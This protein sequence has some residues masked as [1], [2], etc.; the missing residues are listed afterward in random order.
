MARQ[1]RIEYP[2]AI[3]HVMSRGN[4]S[5][6][7]YC[8]D[9]DRQCFLELLENFPER[10]NIE[11]YAYVLMDNHYHLLLKTKEANLSRAMQWF[12]TT[13]TRKF[14]LKNHDKGHLFQGRFKSI[15]VE[16]DAYLLR[17]SYYIHCNPLRAGIVKRLVDFPWSSYRF[18]AYKKRPPLWLS[19]KTI[20]NQLSGEDLHKSYR[21]KMQHYSKEQGSVWEEVRHGFI[22][23][24]QDFVTDLKSR[25]LGSKKEVELPQHNSLFK[26]FDLESLLKSASEILDINIESVRHSRKIAP[27]EK[28]KRDMLVYL[29]WKTGR[30]SNY[31]IGDCLGLTYSSISK[32]VSALHGRITTENDFRGRWALLK[33]QFKV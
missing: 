11:V 33:S 4:G 6:D 23:G 5:Q 1:W 21:L 19:T 15:I 28:D 2:G 27:I 3:Y 9:E 8:S 17:L 16:N 30:F 25:F 24:S 22:Y 13:Y 26:E 14:N 10:Y 31:E 29:L 32:I 7:I 12:G 20:T 18:Y